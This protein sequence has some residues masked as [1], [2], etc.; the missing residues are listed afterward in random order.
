[1][2]RLHEWIFSSLAPLIRVVIS[3]M[4]MQ[5]FTPNRY[6]AAFL[7]LL[8]VGLFCTAF[9]VCSIL[10]P[11]FDPL[12]DFIS[13]LGAQG[14]PCEVWWNAIGFLT[15]GVTLAAFGYAFGRMITDTTTGLWLALSGIGFALAAIPTDL[16]N[17]EA[18]LSKAHF[19]SICLALA[20][21]CFGLARVSGLSSLNRFVK[22]KA[23]IASV[24]VVIP[25]I[26]YGT[27]LITM[28]TT[29]RL[30]LGV[31]FGWVTF[32]S[33]DL[34]SKESMTIETEG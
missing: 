24:L 30:V 31:V 16:V 15:V 27:G 10:T 14:Q 5:P 22:R 26:G 28:P 7:G 33:L 8:G 23:E 12:D 34:L 32:T 18:S 29:H 4:L 17:A 3:F 6:I 13:K 9:I 25:M 20:G 1:M 21:W 19:V 2:A 11:D